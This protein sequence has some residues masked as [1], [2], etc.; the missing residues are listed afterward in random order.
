MRQH[1]ATVL[2]RRASMRLQRHHG[3][4]PSLILRKHFPDAFG[5]F[6]S[7]SLTV[8]DDLSLLVG[9][10]NCIFKYGQAVHQR[11]NLQRKRLPKARIDES[12]VFSTGPR[13]YVSTGP[14]GLMA[15]GL[16]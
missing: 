4:H 13:A 12:S 16:I 2:L 10:I 1:S 7:R 8:C 14:P 9:D 3:P 5:N 15:L 6:P 11:L